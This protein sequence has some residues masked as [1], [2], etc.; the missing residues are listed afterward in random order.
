MV[1]VPEFAIPTR[2]D[3]IFGRN[4]RLDRS[5]NLE[6]EIKN[7]ENGNFADLE[8]ENFVIVQVLHDSIMEL[9]NRRRRS[10]VILV[11]RLLFGL[12][13]TCCPYSMK[14]VA[15]EQ[16][17]TKWDLSQSCLFFLPSVS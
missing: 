3:E 16:T 1:P 11:N 9:F 4:H 6:R 14:N 13:F 12:C 5:R 8:L 2:R 10:I 7:Y 17:T 15:S